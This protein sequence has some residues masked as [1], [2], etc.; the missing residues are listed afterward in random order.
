MPIGAGTLAAFW[1]AIGV[2]LIGHTVNFRMIRVNIAAYR[3]LKRG[4]MRVTEQ[5]AK[6]AGQFDMLLA[7]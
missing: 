3:I 6:M 2:N 5:R 7:G 4:F 1:R